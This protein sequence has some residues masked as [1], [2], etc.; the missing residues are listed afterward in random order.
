[1]PPITTA[2]VVSDVLDLTASLMNDTAKQ[3]FTYAA[4]LPYFNMALQDLQLKLELNEVG[5]SE[6]T[7]AAVTVTK[8]VT[9]IVASSTT[10]PTYPA[11]LVEIQQLWERLAGS[12]DPFVPMFK[13]DFLP[14]YLDNIQTD[15]LV[16]WTWLNQEIQMIG[17]TTDREV[18][19]DYIKQYFANSVST[20]T[21]AV[22][23]INARTFLMYRTAGL[24]AQYIGENATRAEALN[25]DAWGPDH[26]S[27][28]MG[29]LL[30]INIKGKQDVQVRRKP[31]LSGYKMRSTM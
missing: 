26:E 8:G 29:D 17:A 7:A 25:N 18:K 15:C 4:M 5:V 22:D 6:Q 9:S 11:D 19:I 2:V 12:N 10:L 27:G 14:H 3:K 31:F 30:A 24:C 21:A 16:Y 13:R 1:M 20:T 28:A 23:V